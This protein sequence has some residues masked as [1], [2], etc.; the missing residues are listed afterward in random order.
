MNIDT[1]GLIAIR[2]FRQHITDPSDHLTVSRDLNGF[3]SQ[4]I[5]S[6]L[7]SLSLRANDRDL[8]EGMV[9]NWTVRGTVH[10]FAEDD[11]PIYKFDKDNHRSLD[12]SGYRHYS[13]GEPVISPEEQRYWSLRIIDLVKNGISLRED[14][15]RAC[16]EEG[17]SQDALDAMF[18][19]WGGGIRELCERG[20]LN[21]RLTEKKG[22]EISPDFL[23]V[24]RDAAEK[25]IL[26]R[27]FSSYGPASLRDAAY[28][29]GCSQARIK[30][31]IKSLP[32][33][34]VNIFGKEHYY[35]GDLAA[36]RTTIP[37]CLFLGGF[38]PLMLGYRKDESVFLPDEYLRGI[39]TLSGIVMP[40]VMYKGKVAG[41]W[42]RQ[43]KK[44]R[45]QFFGSADKDV[46][47]AVQNTAEETFGL[48]EIITEMI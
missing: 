42:K 11:L 35:I 25:E 8:T 6:A 32:V 24:G 29:Y 9:R 2:L 28:Y 17:M 3:Q 33:K 44:I 7:H 27:Y 31:I 5:S 34:S 12:F 43:G 41:R 19:Q 47:I 22:F 26:R 37:E 48:P 36:G 21:Y 15:K 46:V 39:F 38:D 23:P 14:L 13:S 1:E 18:D 16:A 10:I 45:I 20:F 40:A 4:F 30:E